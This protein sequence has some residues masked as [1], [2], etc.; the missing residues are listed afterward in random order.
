MSHHEKL[1]VGVLITSM[2]YWIRNVH[3]IHVYRVCYCLFKL[4]IVCLD[5]KKIRACMDKVYGYEYDFVFKIPVCK[6]T[7]MYLHEYLR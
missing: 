6:L 7:Y 5:I 4:R 3:L 2:V 1:A